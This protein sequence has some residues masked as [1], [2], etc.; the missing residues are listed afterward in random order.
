MKNEDARKILHK[1]GCRM[2]LLFASFFEDPQIVDSIM[3][4]AGLMTKAAGRYLSTSLN[5]KIQTIEDG[6]KHFCFPGKR[7]LYIYVLAL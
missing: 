5:K 1:A 3:V 2:V 6:G 7:I 4:L